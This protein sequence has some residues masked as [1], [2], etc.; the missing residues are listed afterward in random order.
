MKYSL[1][2]VQVSVNVHVG[3]YTQTSNNQAVEGY[4]RT[5]ND[6][7]ANVGFAIDDVHMDVSGDELAESCKVLSDV[8]KFNLDAQMARFRKKMEIQH[9]EAHTNQMKAEK[10]LNE[11]R[12]KNC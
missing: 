8:I 1:G 11:S 12:N 7:D 5:L 6:F 3:G 4:D 10:E 9:I 2:K